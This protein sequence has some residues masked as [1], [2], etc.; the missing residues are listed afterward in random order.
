MPGLLLTGAT[1]L[2]GSYV[3]RDCLRAGLPIAVLVRPTRRAT[4]SERV[5][6]L[7]RPWE[8]ETGHDMPRPVVL[9]GDLNEPSLGLD[10]AGR[11]WLAGHCDAILHSA[12]SLSFQEEADGEPWRTNVAGTGRLL[13]LARQTGIRRFHH[14]STAYVCGLR[15]GTVRE[16]ELDVGQV[17][18]N[19]YEHSKLQ[20][21]AMVRNAPFLDV[22]TVYRPSIIVGDS[23]T[24]H[25][26]SFH[27]FYTPLRI[28]AAMVQAN[29]IRSVPERPFHDGLAM[30]GRER[31]N[32]VPVDWVSA[33]LTRIVGRPPFHGRTY[34]LT[35]PQPTPVQLMYETMLE[36][37][38]ARAAAPNGRSDQAGPSQQELD[39]LFR[40]QLAVYQSYWRDDPAFDATHSTAA[41]PELPCP[42]LDRATLRRLIDFA[43]DS[44]FGWP[45]PASRFAKAHTALSR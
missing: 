13:Q 27:G 32:F 4:A 15:H 9:E 17:L 28:A 31:K 45:A 30:T 36:A 42:V 16:D 22:V 19:A 23:R 44:N 7:L 35:N 18:G 38:V 11:R 12:A 43:L 1:G 10:D 3:L 5:E 14:V 8:G 37:L 20:A 2:L 21:E 41:V 24:G 29:L 40:K 34:H 25:T 33:V 26:T 39:Q 6:G